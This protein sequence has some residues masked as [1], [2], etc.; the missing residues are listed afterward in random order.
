MQGA[1]ALGARCREGK[2]RNVENVENVHNVDFQRGQA[3]QIS[4]R[5][6][7]KPSIGNG[8]KIRN[9]M[10]STIGEELSGRQ[11]LWMVMDG[12]RTVRPPSAYTVLST[13]K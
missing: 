8:R 5:N 6:I 1:F 11:K 4:C 9:E 10:F 7:S 13:L 2:C 12:H 3:H